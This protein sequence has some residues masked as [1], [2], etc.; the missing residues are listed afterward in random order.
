MYHTIEVSDTIS[1]SRLVPKDRHSLTEH[2]NDEDIAA[3][4]LTI[5]YPY[6]LSYADKYL[7]KI[8]E[9]E[10]KYEKQK[11]WAIRRDNEVIGCIGLLYN[12]GIPSHRT[13]IGYWLGKAFR[14]QGI[15]SNVVKS[16]TEFCT[17][18][19]GFIRMEANVFEENKASARVL[20]KA[21]YK[22]E[23]R[24][25]ASYMKN[26]VIRSSLLYAYIHKD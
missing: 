21:G 13:E 19:Y 12:F 18:Q 5:P 25:E 6:K 16:F 2:I 1:L 3:N 7:T 9:F 14:G 23:A 11:E 26:G 20:E 24:L 17:R 22:F 15:M 10:D 4:T 8:R